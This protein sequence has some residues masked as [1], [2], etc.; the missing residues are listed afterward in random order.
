[1]AKLQQAPSVQDQ[2]QL[3]MQVERNTTN[4]PSCH[5]CLNIDGSLWLSNA[6]IGAI[7]H[8]GVPHICKLSNHIAVITTITP[9]AHTTK[10]KCKCYE[11]NQI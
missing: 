7:T 10:G 9:R 11:T 1:M 5:L 2:G 4:A 6:L 3:V 8:I